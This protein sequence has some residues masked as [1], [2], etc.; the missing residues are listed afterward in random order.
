VNAKD[1][2][3]LLDGMFVFSLIWSIGGSTENEGRAK[4][5]DF[6]RKLLDQ[7]GRGGRGGGEWG[8]RRGGGARGGRGCGEGQRLVL[9]PS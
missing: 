7:V 6:F 1:V 3:K 5:S 9:L 2:P 4:F 8:G